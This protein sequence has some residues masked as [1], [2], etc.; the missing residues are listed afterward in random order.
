M[1]YVLRE[2]GAAKNH[3]RQ[4]AEAIVIFYLC[5]HFVAR[6]FGQV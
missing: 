2:L 1:I 5:Q 3:K 6:Y 4:H